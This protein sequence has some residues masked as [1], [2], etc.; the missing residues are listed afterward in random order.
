[1]GKQLGPYRIPD[2]HAGLACE[3]LDRS[4]KGVLLLDDIKQQIYLKS[5]SY[6]RMVKSRR[7]GLRVG[8]GLGRD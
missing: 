3:G 2:P 1:M 8:V 7:W 6:S 4:K 5:F